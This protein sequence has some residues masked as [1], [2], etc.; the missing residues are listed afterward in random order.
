[1]VLVEGENDIPGEESTL[2]RQDGGAT[3]SIILLALSALLW[4]Y[5]YLG[6]FL[7]LFGSHWSIAYK[8]GVLE[9]IYHVCSLVNRINI[10][11]QPF[12]I[13][14]HTPRDSNMCRISSYRHVL[15]L[16]FATGLYSGSKHG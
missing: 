1:M 2:E 11:H 12:L 10:E 14:G 4:I 13:Q 5:I 7:L 6:G 8:A 3:T 16:T 9:A 15:V